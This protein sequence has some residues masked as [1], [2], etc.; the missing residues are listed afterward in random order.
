MV[1]DVTHA[2]DTM[3]SSQKVIHRPS[4]EQCTDALAGSRSADTVLVVVPRIKN[5]LSCSL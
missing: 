4:G 5:E 2:C 1:T 3:L